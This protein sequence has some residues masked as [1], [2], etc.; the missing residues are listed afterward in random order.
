MALTLR[1]LLGQDVS[2]MRLAALK[3]ALASLAET[4]GRSAIGFQFRH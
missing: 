1:T 2:E 3:L 4:L